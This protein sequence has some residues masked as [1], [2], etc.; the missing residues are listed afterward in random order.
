MRDH[1]TVIVAARTRASKNF[2]KFFLDPQLARLDFR[3]TFGKSFKT[4]F[5]SAASLRGFTGGTMQ[6]IVAMVRARK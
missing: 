6:T 4:L 1:T 2:A 3:A 5:P